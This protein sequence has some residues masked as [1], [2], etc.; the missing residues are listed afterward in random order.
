MQKESEKTQCGLKFEGNN[1]IAN[2]SKNFGPEKFKSSYALATCE[3]KSCPLSD[4]VT[5]NFTT[6]ADESRENIAFR[7]ES[8]STTPGESV[9]RQ[10][11]IAKLKGCIAYKVEISK[12][13]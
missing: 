11:A 2:D 4:G 5:V 13:S 3:Y 12:A 7:L 10:I 6:I 8:M 1:V 9:N